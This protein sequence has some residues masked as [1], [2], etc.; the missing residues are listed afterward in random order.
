MNIRTRFFLFLIPATFFSH[1]FIATCMYQTWSLEV[2]KQFEKRFSAALE[3]KDALSTSE[4]AQALDKDFF[5][6]TLRVIP[7]MPPAFHQIHFKTSYYHE[8][9]FAYLPPTKMRSAIQVDLAAKEL[10][11]E[12]KSGIFWTAT[13]A[14]MSMGISLCGLFLATRKITAPIEDL[15][16]AALA[17]AAGDYGQNISVKGPKEIQELSNTLSVMSECL[18]ENSQRHKESLLEKPLASYEETSARHLQKMMFSMRAKDSNSDKISIKTLALH[19]LQPKGL[20]LELCDS[21]GAPLQL[22]LFEAN[23]VG[24]AGMYNLLTN[25]KTNQESFPQI[26]AS[27]DARSE[28]FSYQTKQ[29]PTPFLWS[30]REKTFFPL[31]EDCTKVDCG[32][33][34]FLYTPS[35]FSLYKTEKEMQK[36]LGKVLKFFAEEGLDPLSKMLYKEIHF[37][38]KKQ[39][40]DEDIH[41]LFF[42]IL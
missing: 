36:H 22:S 2:Q 1:I 15:K 12:L 13:A 11:S 27:L 37:F 33:C 23:Q 34:I 16:K 31:K 19:S 39:D 21:P 42:Q 14:L 6:K 9:V 26:S 10:F 7:N 35:L 3:E 41:L 24:L 18:Y 40:F 30:F 38:A 28:L 8:T 25:H 29:F 32:D 4:L 17:I 5:L 20:L